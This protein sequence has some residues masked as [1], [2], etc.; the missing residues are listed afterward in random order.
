M[1]TTDANRISPAYELKDELA[2][3]CLPAANRDP[4][5][6]LG[7]VNSIC[8]LFLTIG[9]FGAKLGV[10]SHVTPPPIEQ[11]I[12]T[13]LEPVILPP[14][15][16]ENQRQEQTEQEKTETP[17]V[18]VVTPESPSIN[19]SVPTIGSLVV[20]AAL[21]SP[22]PLKPM[23]APEPVRSRLATLGNTGSGGQRPQ[24]PYPKIA[25][26]QAAQGTVTL[27]LTGDAAGNIASLQLK[28]SSGSGILDRATLDFIKHHWTLPAGTTNQV[29]ETSIIYQLQTN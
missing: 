14:Q 6:K 12:P 16:A 3:L 11:V 25:L 26:E 22:P 2:R 15:S 9:I 8:I 24:P 20:P 19:F 13:I 29:F 27:L 4:N 28:E 5:R 23:Q 21:A 17:Q 7:W 18:V 1:K 10:I